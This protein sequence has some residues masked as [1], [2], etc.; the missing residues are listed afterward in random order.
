MG[1]LRVDYGSRVYCPRS[2]FRPVAPE[3]A[4]KLDLSLQVPRIALCELYGIPRRAKPCSYPRLG[5]ARRPDRPPLSLPL[6]CRDFS[7]A[8]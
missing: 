6:E 7:G 5:A 2:L 8:L 3:R 1:S 4:G